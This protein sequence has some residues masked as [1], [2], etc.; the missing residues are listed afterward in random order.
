MDSIRHKFRY[1]ISK[2]YRASVRNKQEIQNFFV[3]LPKCTGTV[4]IADPT[5]GDGE[6]RCSITIPANELIIWAQSYLESTTMTEFNKLTVRLFKA[7]LAQADVNDER[8]T[9]LPEPLYRHIN[10]VI[11]DWISSGK[12]TVHC[13][14]CNQTV[15][16]IAF[17]E[18]DRWQIGERYRFWTELWHC[19]AR[20]ELY[21]ENR[22][23][24]TLFVTD[25]LKN[26]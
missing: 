12:A 16:D 9:H 23:L 5:H 26:S 22:T 1:L 20:H 11:P 10:A 6:Y 15:T 4:L 17:E 3:N 14:S 18:T 13:H 7:W 25:H 19:P 8:T 24:R 21:R 2:S